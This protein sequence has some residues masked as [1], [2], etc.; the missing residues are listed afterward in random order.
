MSVDMGGGFNLAYF[1]FTPIG[2]VA[3]DNRIAFNFSSSSHKRY[4]GRKSLSLKH[5]ENA[6][7]LAAARVHWIRAPM[8]E[9]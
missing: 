5:D 3:N 7:V 9:I 4:R 1:S 8:E 2:G 6:V